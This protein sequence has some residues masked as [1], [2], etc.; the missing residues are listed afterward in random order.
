MGIIQALPE[1]LV[2]LNVCATS[3]LTLGW[4]AIRAGQRE[5]HRKIMTANLGVAVLFLIAYITLIT[6]VGHERYDGEG[7]LRPLF[8]TILISHTILAVSLVG[9]VPRTVYLAWKQ[10][11]Q[12]HRRL[13]RITIRMWLYVTVTGIVIY[14]MLHHLPLSV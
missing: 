10:R 14:L 4:L 12:E 7:W 6:V 5:R 8:F 11:F 3:L 13:A 2:A 1:I 9:F